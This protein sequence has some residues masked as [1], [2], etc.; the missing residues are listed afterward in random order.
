VEAR[1]D[2]RGGRQSDVGLAPAALAHVRF[3]GGSSGSG[4]ST[5]ARQLAREHRLLL[6][7]AEQFSAYVPRTTAEDAP[8]LHAFLAM[9]MDERWVTRSPEVMYETFHGFHGE[10][11]PHVV[12]DLLAAPPTEPVLVE[13]FPL[14]PKL[15]APLLSRPDQAVWL[16]ASPAFRRAAFD[17]RSSTWEIPRRTSDPERAL[18]NL[19]ARDALFGHAVRSQAEALDLQVVDVDTG[20]SVEELV[21]V[22]ARA[23][24]LA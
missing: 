23:L 12:E 9:D 5:V 19:Y 22:V 10:T 13:G 1:L 20:T 6:V 14:L 8:L 16:V 11:F 4:K 15:V 24:G 21:A 3:I 17:S 7:S 2:G 18:E